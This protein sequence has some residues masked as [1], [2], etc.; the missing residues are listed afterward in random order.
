MQRLGVGRTVMGELELALGLAH[1]ALRRMGR[2]DDD[3]DAAVDEL[4][5]AARA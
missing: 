2:S 3:D 4:R 1:F 5:L